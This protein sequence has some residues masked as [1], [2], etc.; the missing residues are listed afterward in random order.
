MA[1]YGPAQAS[2]DQQSKGKVIVVCSASGGMGRSSV[3][4]N[5]AALAAR[6]S[7]K[8]DVIDGDLQFG[9]LALSLNLRPS[10]SIE[11][12]AER[13]DVSNIREYCIA[14]ESGLQLLAAPSRPEFADLVSP[15]FVTSVLEELSRD[16]GAVILETQAGL[17]EDN[18]QFMELADSIIVV[19]STGMAAIKNT[20]LMIETIKALGMKEKVIV[21][22]NKCT[23]L[24]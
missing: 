3:T 18:L 20:K 7:V 8:V 14:H 12:A 5:L 19:A 11:E 23:D 16:S 13:K 24:P 2:P 9:D 22:V 4:L 10:L 6:Q 21:V 1:S 17:N 15:E